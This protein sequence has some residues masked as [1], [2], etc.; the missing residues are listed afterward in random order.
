MSLQTALRLLRMQRTD[1]A[2]PETTQE[3]VP[4]GQAD[5]IAPSAGGS[6][7]PVCPAS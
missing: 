3:P 6:G 1:G 2:R 7:W 5:E 4:P